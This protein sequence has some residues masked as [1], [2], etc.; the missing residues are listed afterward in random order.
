[1]APYFVNLGISGINPPA[2]DQYGMDPDTLM[3][4]YS[5][6]YLLRGS[7]G[8]GQQYAGS[9]TVAIDARAIYDR[10]NNLLASKTVA[11]L[12]FARPTIGVIAKMLAAWSPAIFITDQA[13]A[14][15]TGSAGA[16]V[17]VEEH[18]V[19]DFNQY[20]ANLEQLLNSQ[21]S[22]WQAQNFTTGTGSQTTTALKLDA[23]DEQDEVFM[24]LL[25]AFANQPKN[26][27]YFLD[28]FK[29]ISHGRKIF[30]AIASL[31]PWDASETWMVLLRAES[32][33]L[34]GQS[35]KFVPELIEYAMLLALNPDIVAIENSI[36]P[37][38]L[39]AWKFVIVPVVQSVVYSGLEPR[40]MNYMQ[41]RPL[42][43]VTAPYYYHRRYTYMHHTSLHYHTTG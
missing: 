32:N 39:A 37:L 2:Y 40:I 25:L 23:I 10:I 33:I 35:A 24:V 18:V 31:F 27:D 28:L 21:V 41:S 9:P 7:L 17:A 38:Q 30:A 15:L 36:S 11:P 43:Y 6:T 16:G 3:M 42:S 20:L 22:A 12:E 8:S 29:T 14:Q 19:A 1:W 4:D 13:I 26:Y 34:R 5:T